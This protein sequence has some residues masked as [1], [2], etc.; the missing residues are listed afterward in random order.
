[1]LLIYFGGQSVVANARALLGLGYA[2]V[3]PFSAAVVSLALVFGT[4]MGEAIRGA[5]A[6]RARARSAEAADWAVSGSCAG[7]RSRNCSFTARRI[8]LWAVLVKTTPIAALI[9]LDDVLRRAQSA[10]SATQQPLAY[11]GAVS[12]AFLV[13]TGLSEAAARFL[14]ARAGARV[15]S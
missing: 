8:H 9:G 2:D 7:S 5:W 1:M 15:A 11:Y 12:V 14:A 13:V 3:D 6:I 10:A 4:Y